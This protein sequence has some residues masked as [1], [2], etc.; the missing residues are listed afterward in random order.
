MKRQRQRSV[1][2]P[3]IKNKNDKMISAW[4]TRTL[5]IQAVRSGANEE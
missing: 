1:I 3:V 5:D 2:N 4:Q